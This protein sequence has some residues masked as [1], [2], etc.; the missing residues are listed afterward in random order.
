[1]LESNTQFN[2]LPA[3]IRIAILMCLDGDHAAIFIAL[4]VCKECADVLTDLLWKDASPDKFK[5]LPL[6]KK[7]YYANKVQSRRNR[8]IAQSFLSTLK[9]LFSRDCAPGIMVS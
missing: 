1:M 7:Q 3:K 5:G 4:S 8:S 6:A 9:T 2:R